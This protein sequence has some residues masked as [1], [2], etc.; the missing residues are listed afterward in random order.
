MRIA[1]LITYYNE[2]SLLTECLESLKDAMCLPDEIVVYD[3]ASVVPPEPYIPRGPSVR[4][5]KGRE[6]RGPAYGRNML[7]EACNCEY[8]HF[9]DADDLFAPGWCDEV[10]TRLGNRDLDALFT[11]V[12][13]YRDG[14]V[15]S[16]R[17]MGLEELADHGDLLRFCIRQALLTISGT[18][19]RD[20]V[21]SIGGYSTAYWQSE[22][23]EFHIR[24]ARSSPRFD[25]ICRPLALV[26]TH[27]G[28][29]SKDRRRVW[30]DAIR[31]LEKHGRDLDP[32]HLQDACDAAAKAG[33]ILYQL[34]AIEEARYAFSV[35]RR[36]GQPRFDEEAPMF[37]LIAT[38]CGPLTAE[39]IG[40][41]Y[42]SALPAAVRRRVRAMLG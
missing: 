24:L 21:L 12:A 5:I 8:V 33:R 2:A 23:Y 25:L 3:D 14:G 32:L 4:V 18:Y 1:V 15:S 34:G 7:L 6:N 19:R 31:A 42:R 35:A 22:D 26:R 17:V 39:R 11:E 38:H 20:H 30:V 28:N 16:E 37:R 13:S 41:A 9:H 29:R 27:E 10:S 36:I 40:Q